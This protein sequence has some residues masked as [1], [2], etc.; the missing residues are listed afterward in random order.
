[1]EGRQILEAIGKT[2]ERI[3]YI[4]SKKKL[5]KVIKLDRSK[6]YD[7]TNWLYLR[8]I[9]IHVEFNLSVVSWI[10]SSVTSMKFAL[11]INVGASYFFKPTRVLMQWCPLSPLLF[12][13]IVEG[14]SRTI[15]EAKHRSIVQGIK[16]GSVLLTHLLFV[17]DIMLFLNGY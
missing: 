5:A 12:L 6:A 17:D 16:I 4:K 10:M 11:L 8:L 15:I 14:I 9:L 7:I 1:L 3:H 2:H 13:L